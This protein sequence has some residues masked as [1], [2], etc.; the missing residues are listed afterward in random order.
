VAGLNFRDLSTR[1]GIVLEARQ[2]HPQHLQTRL[3]MRELLPT[4]V[5]PKAPPQNL[6]PATAE[7]LYHEAGRPG[8][9]GVGE[10][11][12]EEGSRS[13]QGEEG[14]RSQQGEEEVEEA[15]AKFHRVEDKKERPQVLT[16]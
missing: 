6:H 12:E 9:L 4:L 15:Q 5:L 8:A 2:T 11:E 13:Q 1:R 14:S 16:S 7:S 10:A 3:R